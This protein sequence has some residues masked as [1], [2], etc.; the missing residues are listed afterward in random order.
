MKYGKHFP[1]PDAQSPGVLQTSK[2]A[3][4]IR[5]VQCS[6]GLNSVHE[7]KRW[8]GF[9]NSERRQGAWLNK[10]ASKLRRQGTYNAILPGS[11]EPRFR[12]NS[13]WIYAPRIKPFLAPTVQSSDAHYVLPQALGRGSGVLVSCMTSRTGGLDS[14]LPTLNSLHQ[15]Q[16]R[17]VQTLEP[18]EAQPGGAG[19]GDEEAGKAGGVHLQW[20][21][22]FYSCLAVWFGQ[23][24]SHLWPQFPPL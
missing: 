12:N 10:V 6:K 20:G 14:W 3:N 9:P 19:R 21:D 17:P 22:R 16:A 24:T 13:S 8:G 5:N 1:P 2:R 11:T 15:K 18:G 7:G 23:V 4:A